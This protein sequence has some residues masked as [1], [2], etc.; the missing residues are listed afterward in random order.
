MNTRRC[1]INRQSDII[2]LAQVG[3]LGSTRDGQELLDEHLRV[4]RACFNFIG[5]SKPYSKLK[6]NREKQTA[7]C[8]MVRNLFTNKLF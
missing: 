3:S 7:E 2:L 1:L 5:E 4:S 8:L 6:V